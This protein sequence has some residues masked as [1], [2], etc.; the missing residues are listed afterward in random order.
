[1]LSPTGVRVSQI[2][3]LSSDNTPGVLWTS[4]SGVNVQLLGGTPVPLTACHTQLGNYM[5]ATSVQLLP[6]FWIASW[7]KAGPGYLVN[8]GKGIA[9]SGATCASD[10]ACGWPSS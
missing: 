10:P 2:T 1:M 9:C 5:S 8:E 7:T 4:P 6:G 3:P